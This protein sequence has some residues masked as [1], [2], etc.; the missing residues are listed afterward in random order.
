MAWKTI[1]SSWGKRPLFRGKLAAVFQGGEFPRIFS[2]RKTNITME[3]QQFQDVFPIPYHP[4]M[5]YLP[6]FTI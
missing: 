5:V 1:V 6:T 2:T 4:C 3:N